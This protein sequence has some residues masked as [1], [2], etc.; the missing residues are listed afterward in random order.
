[1]TRVFVSLSRANRVRPRRT[2]YLHSNR[3]DRSNRPSSRGWLPTTNC[4][5]DTYCERPRS[6][7]EA[8]TSSSLLQVQSLFPL[9]R[10]P[11]YPFVA[12]HHDWSWRIRFVDYSVT[13]VSLGGTKS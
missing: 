4:L 9:T 7:R 13:P 3:L 12:V 10:S 8:P 5:M 6:W 1:P 11:G 2:F